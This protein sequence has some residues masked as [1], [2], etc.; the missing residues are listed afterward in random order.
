MDRKYIL[1]LAI[2]LSVLSPVAAQEH[3]GFYVKGRH[4]YDPCG[5]KV[6]LRG[7]ANP[8]IWFENDGG[9][10]FK[11]IEKTGANVIRSSLFYC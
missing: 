8:N 1:F 7:V 10:K 6:I 2:L 3:P 9:E 11:E 4:L 5:E